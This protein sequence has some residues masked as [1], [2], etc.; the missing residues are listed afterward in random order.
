M[1]KINDCTIIMLKCLPEIIYTH[2][3]Q[4]IGTNKKFEDMVKAGWP[5]DSPIPYINKDVIL[6]HIKGGVKCKKVLNSE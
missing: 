3:D 1:T 5:G 2:V 4:K 6:A